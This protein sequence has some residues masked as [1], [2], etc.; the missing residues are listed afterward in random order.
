MEITKLSLNSQGLH[1]LFQ[2]TGLTLLGLSQ[3]TSRVI[4][5]NR[6]TSEALVASALV[7][8]A[9]VLLQPVT[10]LSGIVTMMKATDSSEDS[11]LSTIGSAGRLFKSLKN[12]KGASS[13]HDALGIKHTRD[14]IGFVELSIK[15][16]LD[17]LRLAVSKIDVGSLTEMNR[18]KNLLQFV[19]MPEEE[20]A[21]HA[22]V[23]DFIAVI[24]NMCDWEGFT[25]VN[26]K[27]L[28]S[29]S[30]NTS[31]QEASPMGIRW[32]SPQDT[33]HQ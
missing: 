31:S 13:V 26:I 24:T 33:S 21:P 27:N 17:V 16:A 8:I 1:S 14:S 25:P 23:N 9:D 20:V 29:T 22:A 6:R 18:L 3:D 11:F 30:S 15:E 19:R 2:Q 5:V 12:M 28:L 4:S 32:S 10:V 7:I